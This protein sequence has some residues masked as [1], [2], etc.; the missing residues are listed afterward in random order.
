MPFAK[1][2]VGTV[3]KGASPLG[4]LLL[5]PRRSKLANRFYQQNFPTYAPPASYGK[6]YENATWR[7]FAAPGC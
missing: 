4:K 5:V 1:N 2:S 7:V 6:L 3:E